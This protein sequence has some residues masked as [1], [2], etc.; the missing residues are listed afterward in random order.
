LL[1]QAI[2]NNDLD[3]QD[4]GNANANTVSGEIEM[5]DGIECVNDMAF[6]ANPGF[7]VRKDKNGNFVMRPNSVYAGNLHRKCR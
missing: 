6:T 5:S 1:A 3:F 7:K 4:Y 2:H